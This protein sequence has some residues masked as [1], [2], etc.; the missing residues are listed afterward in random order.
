[1]KKIRATQKMVVSI[2]FPPEMVTALNQKL[3]ENE[4]K[5]G[6]KR[7]FSWIVCNL[8]AEYVPG[9]PKLDPNIG[10]RN[11]R[12]SMLNPV[13]ELPLV[14]REPYFLNGVRLFSRDPIIIEDI[15][16]YLMQL[17][18]KELSYDEI[19]TLFNGS[20]DKA[21]DVTEYG[22]EKKLAQSRVENGIIYYSLVKSPKVE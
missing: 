22:Q 5:L 11:R 4:T 19:V 3:F 10:Y 14:G 15:E 17:E 1:M 18:E 13:I 9:M 7:S 20:T 6:L 12:I 2:S 16:F 8:L 21:D